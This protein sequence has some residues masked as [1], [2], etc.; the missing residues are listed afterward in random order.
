[1]TDENPETEPPEVLYRALGHLVFIFSHLDEGLHQAIK[2]RCGLR[3]EVSILTS[4]LRFPELVDR[5]RLLFAD[6]EHP[7]PSTERGVSALCKELIALNEERNRQMH[8]TWG[9]WST[10][11]PARMRH[12]IGKGGMNLSLESVSVTDLDALADRMHRAADKVYELGFAALSANR[13]ESTLPH[14]EA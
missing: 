9:F 6:F 5:F 1:M 7:A 10:G 2:M 13:R 3:E 14:T 8:S 11:G 4:G 12:R